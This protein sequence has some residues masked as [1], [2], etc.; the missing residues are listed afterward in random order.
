MS[1]VRVPFLDP[2]SDD[3]EDRLRDQ[4]HVREVEVDR[5][6]VAEDRGGFVANAAVAS[7]DLTLPAPPAAVAPVIPFAGVT[8]VGV[9]PTH[10]RRGLLRRLMAGMLEDARAR[11]E[12]LR[13]VDRVR[14]GHLRP[15]RIRPG[16][17]RGR[18]DDRQSRRRHAGAATPA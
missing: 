5:A 17:Q 15:L 8:A 12:R 1:S 9:H 7:L 4:R 10:R 16:H 11:G 6:W 14:V 3:P 13:R 2:G 18:G